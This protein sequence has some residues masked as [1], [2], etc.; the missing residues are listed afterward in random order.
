MLGIVSQDDRNRRYSNVYA[1]LL[2][3]TTA[4]G[5]AAVLA[6]SGAGAASADDTGPGHSVG[7][8]GFG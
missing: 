8:S 2:R 3:V 5:A 4:L 1:T 6:V 7:S